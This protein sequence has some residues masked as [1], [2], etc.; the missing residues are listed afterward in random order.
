MDNSRSQGVDP[1]KFTLIIDNLKEDTKISQ[2]EEAFKNSN[3]K[4][5]KIEKIAK[6]D[7]EKFGLET[8]F[9]IRRAAHAKARKPDPRAAYFLIVFDNKKDCKFIFV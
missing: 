5:S 8:M 1:Y 4:F 7:Y 2:I 3:S 9:P 6:E